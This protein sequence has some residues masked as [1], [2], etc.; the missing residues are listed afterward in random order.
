MLPAVGL[1]D[2]VPSDASQARTMF[3]FIKVRR[4]EPPARRPPKAIQRPVGLAEAL[5]MPIHRKTH[6]SIMAIGHPLTNR[7]KA[8]SRTVSTAHH[9]V[10]LQ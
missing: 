10:I 1:A 9:A 3:D 4:P 5:I 8:A 7:P 2:A 6:Q